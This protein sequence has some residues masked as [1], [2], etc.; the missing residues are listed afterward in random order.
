MQLQQIYLWS[1]KIHKW[2]IWFVSG[3]GSWMMLSGYLMH[4]E[5]EDELKLNIDMDFVRYWHNGI[6]Q[7]F[8]IIFAL[9]M[10]TGLLIWGVGKILK[11]RA[12]NRVQ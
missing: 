7:Y 12:L 3:L 8:L 2:S 6:S 5:L 10:T 1:K 11:A 9:Q 4:K